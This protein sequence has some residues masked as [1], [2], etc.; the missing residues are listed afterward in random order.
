MVT[1][2]VRRMCF[3][4]RSMFNVRNWATPAVP[5]LGY[6]YRAPINSAIGRASGAVRNASRIAE[7]S[8]RHPK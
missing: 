2:L 3:K 5:V 7:S 6:A 1:N 4:L 8:I